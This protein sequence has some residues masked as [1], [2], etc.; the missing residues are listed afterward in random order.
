MARPTTGDKPQD[1]RRATVDEV[2]AVG[3]T[4]VS[5]N[6]IAA[7]AGLSVGTIYRYHRSKDELLFSVFME[8]K[9]D[10]HAAMM[11]AAADQQ[12]AAARIRAMWFALVHYGFRAPGDFQLVELMSSETRVQFSGNEELKQLQSEVLAEIQKGVDD[13]T[14]VNTSVR[15]IETV[16]ASPA[17][18]LARRVAMGRQMIDE[19]EVE[20]IFALV[21]RGVAAKQDDVSA[22]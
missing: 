9:R 3:S 4:S 7:R 11:T 19:D 22:L 15:T 21:W 6:K 8:V 18:T 2:S 13:G 12:G 5:V 16:L 10:I 1:I 17:I 20:R 14:L